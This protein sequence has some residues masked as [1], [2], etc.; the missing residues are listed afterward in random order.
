MPLTRRSLTLLL[1]VLSLAACSGGGGSAAPTAETVTVAQAAA[2]LTVTVHRTAACGC[3]GQYETYLEAAGITVETMIHDD[4]AVTK[5]G[6][7][8]PDDQRSCHT[9]EL[10]GYAAEGHVPIEALVQLVEEAPEIDGIS[11]A[12]MPSGS[13]GMPGEQEVPFIVHTFV[14]GQVPG[15]LGRF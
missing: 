2:D 6:F 10:A 7:G 1:A 11:L 5:A 9:N 4:M 14:E 3:C 13:P 8:I 15:E 12:G